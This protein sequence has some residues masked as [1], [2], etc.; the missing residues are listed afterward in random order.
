MKPLLL[1]FTF[2]SMV[3]LGACGSSR[4]TADGASKNKTVKIAVISDLNSRYGSVTYN[5]EVSE[6]IN[7]L[8]RLKPDIIVCGGDMV[9][10]QKATLTEENIRAMWQS[11]KQTVLTPLQAAN[12]PF[13]FTLGNHDASPSYTLDRSIA[14]QFWQQHVQATNLQ[15][16]D[17]SHYPFY[18]SYL[19]NNI[20]FISWDAAAA[21]VPQAVYEWM[22]AQLNS[23]AASAANLRIV[24]G[25]L[26]LYAIVAAK[27]KPGEVNAAPDSALQFFKANA[28]DLYIS[29]HQ[30]AWY[31][32]K[33]EGLRLLHAGCIGDG[34]RPILG[35]DSIARKAYT[36]IEVPAKAPKKFSYTTYNPVSKEKIHAAILPDSVIGFNGVVQKD[37][38]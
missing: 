31:P 38:E 12:I 15:F 19:H 36:I 11:F 2:I 27:N 37:G 34:E 28:V 4:H 8:T 10:G 23:K 32:G 13:G 18:F 6:V 22:Q 20:F 26:P 14:Q 3:M 29:G 24:L 1:A 21:R 25:H 5:K 16:V 7:E 9:A 17:S 35:H 33:K 30:H